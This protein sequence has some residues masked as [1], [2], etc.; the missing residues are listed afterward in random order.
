[1]MVGVDVFPFFMAWQKDKFETSTNIITTEGY[2]TWMTTWP[3]KSFYKNQSNRK[4]ITKYSIINFDIQHG[5]MKNKYKVYVFLRYHVANWWLWFFR[6][7]IIINS[8]LYVPYI[9][10]LVF[11]TLISF[12]A[13]R[14][15]LMYTHNNSNPFL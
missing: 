12:H 10:S 2:S 4:I 9:N 1:M 14:F 3:I 8:L 7:L 13:A 15:T 5:V 6:L 11:S